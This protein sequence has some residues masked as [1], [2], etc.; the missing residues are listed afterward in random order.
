MAAYGD[1]VLS[2]I[3]LAGAAGEI[4]GLTIGSAMGLM[5]YLGAPNTQL[6]SYLYFLFLGLG[7]GDAIVLALAFGRHTTWHP[8]RGCGH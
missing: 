5:G 2:G 3:T 8:D 1:S 7:G 6:N 4:V